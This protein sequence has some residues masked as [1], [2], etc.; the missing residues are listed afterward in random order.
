MDTD[1]LGGKRIE[2][3]VSLLW[4]FFFSMLFISHNKGKDDD[5]EEE[6]RLQHCSKSGSGL[7]DWDF[8]KRKWH[9]L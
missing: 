7:W 9:G 2:T 3:K 1:T 8:A 4:G 5:L 6:L